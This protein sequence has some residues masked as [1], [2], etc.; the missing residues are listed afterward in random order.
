MHIDLLSSK[1]DTFLE[2]AKAP[3]SSWKFDLLSMYL[4]TIFRLLI[5]RLLISPIESNSGR[6]FG[7]DC[8]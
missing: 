6:E 3:R 2:N 7:A 5:F 1:E 4:L 8:I